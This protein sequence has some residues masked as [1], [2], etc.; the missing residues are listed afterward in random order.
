MEGNAIAIVFLCGAALAAGYTTIGRIL[1]I[2]RPMP[3]FGGGY[4]TLTGELATAGF[5]G[6]IGLTIIATPVFLIPALVCWVTAARSQSNANRTF[7]QQDE[8]LRA[9]N[10]KNYPGVFDREPPQSLDLNETEDVDVYD[11]GS[12]IYLGR[13]AAKSIENLITATS[14]MPDQG[15]N[16]IY[17]IE[18][19]LEPPIMTEG[20]DLQLFLR[21][22]FDSRGYAVLRWFPVDTCK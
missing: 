2:H 19:M 3:W 9:R 13:I 17:V 18:E 15:P 4:S 11:C 14:D 8:E 22:H 16:D 6:C 7:A 20:N 10:A 12:C 21:E 1:G 5:I